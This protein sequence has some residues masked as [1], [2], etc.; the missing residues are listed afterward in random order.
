MGGCG[1]RIEASS[2][3]ALAAPAPAAAPNASVV[4]VALREIVVPPRSKGHGDQTSASAAT[5]ATTTKE[6]TSREVTEQR[7]RLAAAQASQMKAAAN[8][9]KALVEVVAAEDTRGAPAALEALE[10]L[11]A[12]VADAREEGVAA[13]T[14]R[15]AEVALQL[16]RKQHAEATLRAALVSG[17]EA[18]LAAAV[19]S[20]KKAARRS[21][22]GRAGGGRTPLVDAALITEA[23]KTLTRLRS[24][25]AAR[26]RLRRVVEMSG[27]AALAR[28]I[29][30]ARTDPHMPAGE[31]ARAERVLLRRRREQRILRWLHVLREAQRSQVLA[32]RR[33]LWSKQLNS[34]TFDGSLSHAQMLVS[35]AQLQ[36]Q[37]R[38]RLQQP[39]SASPPAWLY[40]I[41]ECYERFPTPA[42]TPVQLA[43]AHK[44]A[45]QAA[46]SHLRRSVLRALMDLIR[47]YHPD[48]N[49]PES[50][51]EAWASLAEELTKLAVEVHSEYKTRI[52]ALAA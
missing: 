27:P 4:N 51:G 33:S 40:L 43:R 34:R 38:M 6:A 3:S 5:T 22:G 31:V 44:S 39:P 25:S 36:A 35:I 2:A 46:Q 13:A 17:R 19:T 42:L 16:G 14:I 49:R 29:D 26:D 50:F 10:A 30:A 7:A 8:T 21:S 37:V 52:D 24:Q 48:K 9:L 20:V 11:E 15:D 28:A 18:A 47:N 23:E 45:R 41:N 1:S 32:E 12:G